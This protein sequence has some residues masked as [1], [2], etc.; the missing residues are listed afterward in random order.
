M[1]KLSKVE[2]SGASCP[3]LRWKYKK[4]KETRQEEFDTFTLSDGSEID[5]ENFLQALKNSTGTTDVGIGDQ[6]L[7]HTVNGLSSDSQEKKMNQA[8]SMLAALHPQDETEAMLLGQFLALQD[9]G[10][11]CLRQ[12]HSQEMFYHIEKLLSLATKLFNTANQT[13]QALTKYR[14]GG[15]QTVQVI[16]VHNEGQAVVAQNL[17]ATGVPQGKTTN[18]PDGV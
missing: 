13:M 3:H 10:M 17:Q 12:S 8:S 15:K 6:I 5:R 4:N 2:K 18:E 11:K 1:N 14:S 16:H 9:S 7:R